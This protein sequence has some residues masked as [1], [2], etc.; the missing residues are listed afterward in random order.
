[1]RREEKAGVVRVAAVSRRPIVEEE[2]EE[3][4]RRGATALES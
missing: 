1:M 2:Q 3:V 4:G